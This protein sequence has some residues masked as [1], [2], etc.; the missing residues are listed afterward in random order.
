[1][2][3]TQRPVKNLN[4]QQLIV[5]G[6]SSASPGLFL[7]SNFAHTDCHCCN[8]DKFHL[9]HSIHR[10]RKEAQFWLL[11]LFSSLCS[12]RFAPLMG[13]IVAE[14]EFRACTPDMNSLLWFWIMGNIQRVWWKWSFPHH[15]DILYIF[16]ESH[17]WLRRK[18]CN[19]VCGSLCLA[20]PQP[21]PQSL[22]SEIAQTR[23]KEIYEFQGNWHWLKALA[24]VQCLQS[25]R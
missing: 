11:L 8:I 21:P 5:W 13:C 18:C 25:A 16:S 22:H 9:H 4:S 10:L 14:D 15:H 12:N 2:T 3:L 19:K 6:F 1:M 24:E 17:L 7:Y 20:P 23:L